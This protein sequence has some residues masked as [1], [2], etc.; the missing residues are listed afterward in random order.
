MPAAL[1]R[2]SDKY[3]FAVGDDW[4]SINRFA[5]ADLSVIT[6]F[7]KRFGAGT[8]LKLEI[9]FRCPQSLCTVSSSFVVSVRRSHL[10]FAEQGQWATAKGVQRCGSSSS[11]RLAGC[12]GSR[13]STSLR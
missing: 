3:L 7:E 2:G 12:L 4:Q 10:D 5:G 8:T 9:T 6:E 13:S 11:I 1:V